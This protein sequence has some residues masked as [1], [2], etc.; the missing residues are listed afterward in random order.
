MG[1]HPPPYIDQPGLCIECAIKV[2]FP[3]TMCM[4]YFTQA[5]TKYNPVLNYRI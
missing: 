3:Q 4:A 1:K 2:I 5:S